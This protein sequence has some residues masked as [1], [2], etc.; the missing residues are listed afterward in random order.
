[1]LLPYS[2]VVCCF[3]PAFVWRSILRTGLACAGFERHLLSSFL[4]G[5]QCT[6][7]WQLILLHCMEREKSHHVF[8]HSSSPLRPSLSHS[9]HFVSSFMARLF[10]FLPP[11]PRLFQFGILAGLGFCFLVLIHPRKAGAKDCLG[12]GFFD[13]LACCFVKFCYHEQGM[14]ACFFVL[15]SYFLFSF[16]VNH[17]GFILIEDAKLPSVVWI[18]HGECFAALIFPSLLGF[19]RL[20]SQFVVAITMEL[21]ALWPPFVEKLACH[22]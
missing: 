21:S 20:F 9:S 8:T 10:L 16:R 22:V 2:I 17:G 7:F 11:K 12:A 4:T 18:D 13:L 3:L 1:M 6:I 15:H 19:P 14:R 5:G